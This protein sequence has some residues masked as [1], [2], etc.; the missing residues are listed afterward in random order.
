MGARDF[1]S[2]LFGKTESNFGLSMPTLLVCSIFDSK[3]DDLEL[4]QE[5]S[6]SSYRII[7]SDIN[8]EIEF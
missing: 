7:K 4:L 2:R 5:F 1:C 6:Q 3:S 8:N